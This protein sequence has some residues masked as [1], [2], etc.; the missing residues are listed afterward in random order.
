MKIVNRLK[1]II[2]SGCFSV[3]F[4]VLSVVPAFA[5]NVDSSVLGFEL[6]EFPPEVEDNDYMLIGARGGTLKLY[7]FSPEDSK[8]VYLCH[9]S[10]TA[11]QPDGYSDSKVDML[12]GKFSGNYLS[13]YE[14]SYSQEKGYKASTWTRK[15]LTTSSINISPSNNKILLSTFNIYNYRANTF[16]F[17][18]ANIQRFHNSDMMVFL[19]SFGTFMMSFLDTVKGNIICLV[20]LGLLLAGGVVA[21]VYK[22]FSRRFY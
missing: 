14:L 16:I 11:S 2:I 12:S 15:Y 17:F 19:T 21:L 10:S 7:I 20:I 3:M 1:K 4:V 18:H 8:D 9:A 5:W 13:Y 22:V 6:P